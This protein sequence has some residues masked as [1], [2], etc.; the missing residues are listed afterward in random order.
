MIGRNNCLTD[1]D[2]YFQFLILNA[3]IVLAEQPCSALLWRCFYYLNKYFLLFYCSYS[4]PVILQDVIIL[5]G[6]NNQISQLKTLYNIF[7]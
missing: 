6:C 2:V 4:M 7:Y 1:V 5:C 3:E